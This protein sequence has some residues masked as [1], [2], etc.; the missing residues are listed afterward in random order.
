MHH[1]LIE[2]F[3]VELYSDGQ[4]QDLDFCKDAKRNF[5]ASQVR[6]TVQF[7]DFT[8]SFSENDGTW[9]YLKGNYRRNPFFPHDY[10]RKGNKKH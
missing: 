6:V 5:Q 1:F 8:D 9:P 4:V 7:L 10:G 3:Q 2:F